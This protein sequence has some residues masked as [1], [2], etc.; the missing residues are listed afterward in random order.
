MRMR[1][2]YS[3]AAYLIHDIVA[4]PCLSSIETHRKAGHFKH[5]LSPFCM[6]PFL[7]FLRWIWNF[8]ITAF[9]GFLL[10]SYIQ[11]VPC[12]RSYKAIVKTGKNSNI[13]ASVRYGYACVKWINLV[14]LASIISWTHWLWWANLAW[15]NRSYLLVPHEIIPVIIYPLGSSQGKPCP[16]FWYLVK[17]EVSPTILETIGTNCLWEKPS[18]G[19]V[20][21]RDLPSETILTGTVNRGRLC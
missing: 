19:L 9:A 5:L 2:L 11:C 18:K 17:A 10:G 15:P 12:I 14:N 3:N 16:N 20:V 13:M 8:F 1:V 4:P 6:V 7:V 21:S